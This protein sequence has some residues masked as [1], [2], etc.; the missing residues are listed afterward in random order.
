MASYEAD[1]N[2]LFGGGGPTKV[3]GPVA[4][5]AQRPRPMSQ[6][7]KMPEPP[8][9]VA[10]KAV[11]AGQLA[12]ANAML[13]EADAFVTKPTGFAR[14]MWSADVGMAAPRYTKA[15]AL[16]AAAG[17]AQ[18]AQSA[19]IKAADAHTKVQAHSTAAA[20]LEGAAKQAVIAAPAEVGPLILRAAAEWAASLRIAAAESLRAADTLVKGALKLMPESPL[21]ARVEVLEEAMD[22]ADAALGNVSA[23]DVFKAAFNFFGQHG[24]LEAAIAAAPRFFAA[25]DAARVPDDSPGRARALAAVTI[26]H[27]AG[28]DVEQADASF[29]AAINAMSTYC[30]T[31]QAEAAEDLL[32]SIRMPDPEKFHA[33]LAS[34]HL[35][36]LDFE[37][38]ALAKTISPPEA[39]PEEIGIAK[40][41]EPEMDDDDDDDLPDFT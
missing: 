7:V 33:A 21:A 31:S 15:A 10:V 14:L 40:V 5:K 17:D 8:K 37:Y 22:Y 11:N 6:V 19:Y 4:P 34:R 13:A 24:A 12:K 38:A 28:G 18:R 39:P 32:I 26:L 41:P 2:S 30:K 36:T 20:D 35:A 9:S 29:L 23:P 27:L 25:M 3:G 1:R 16:Y